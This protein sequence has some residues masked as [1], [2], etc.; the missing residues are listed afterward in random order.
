MS[1]LPCPWLS[2][3]PGHRFISRTQNTVTDSYSPLTSKCRVKIPCKPF[4]WPWP[5]LLL[6]K[7]SFRA[8]AGGSVLLV[9]WGILVLFNFYNLGYFPPIFVNLQSK[10][11][12]SIWCK[13]G[14][15]NIGEHCKVYDCLINMLCT[16]N[17]YKIM[18]NVN[19]NL[20]NFLQ[21]TVTE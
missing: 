16:W 19:Y 8:F 5:W 2:H 9:H 14:T 18:L 13:V 3:S 1:I 17:K 6:W 12:N 21:T 11:H 4:P 20:K 7:P 15:A 10:C